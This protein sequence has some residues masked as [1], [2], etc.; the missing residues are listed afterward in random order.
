MRRFAAAA[1][2]VSIGGLL[3][4]AAHDALMGPPPAR[5]MQE[6]P[7]PG[8][9]HE[10]YKRDLGRWTA[11]MKAVNVLTGEEVTSRASETNRSGPGKMSMITTFRGQFMGKPFEGQGITGFDDDG[12]LVSCWTDNRSGR[13]RFLK[14]HV[15]EANKKR[16][17]LGKSVHRG[18]V[19]QERHT[20][21]WISPRKRKFTIET[22]GSDRKWLT[23][24][25]VEYTKK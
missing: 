8:P 23:A 15:D 7:K 6:I 10:W 4:A 5:L 18:E 11:T 2:L 12:K 16:V 1:L 25:E 3:G 13:V 9:E 14:G 21:F 24:L 22:Q 17:L 20:V 19:Y